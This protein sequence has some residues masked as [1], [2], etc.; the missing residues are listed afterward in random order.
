MLK[1]DSWVLALALGLSSPAAVA[2]EEGSSAALEAQ[3]QQAAEA[4]RQADIAEAQAELAA[5]QAREAEAE[6]ARAKAQANAE[7]LARAQ[8]VL[9]SSPRHLAGATS[10]RGEQQQFQEIVELARKN[11]MAAVNEFQ[12]GAS[13]AD[14]ASE[15]CKLLSDRT[16]DGWRGTIKSLSSN[17]AGD[18]VLAVEIAEDILLTTS[19]GS[20]FDFDDTVVHRGSPLYDVLRQLSEGAAIEVSGT[21]LASEEDCIKE[22]SLTQYGSMT[23]PEFIVDFRSI[24]AAN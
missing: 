4:Q 11:Y 23:S 13:R 9:K 8:A 24:E 21:F 14:R 7:A 1:R 20:L 15:L 2:A 22:F 17:S 19:R 3:I 5:A 6:A 18:G 12:K 16:F 10:S